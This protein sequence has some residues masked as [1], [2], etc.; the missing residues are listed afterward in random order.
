MCDLYASSMAEGNGDLLNLLH[1]PNQA[2]E[3]NWVR[4]QE[5]AD[6]RTAP[7]SLHCTGQQRR[8]P[9]RSF[10]L[11]SEASVENFTSGHEPSCSSVFVWSRHNSARLGKSARRCTSC[12]NAPGSVRKKRCGSCRAHFP[13][14]QLLETLPYAQ[15]PWS[16]TKR[17]DNDHLPGRC[18]KFTASR[19]PAEPVYGLTRCDGK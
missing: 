17:P 18:G 9:R 4:I 5:R 13:P 10:S 16:R 14:N 8:T 2:N 15:C 19:G 11:E 12:E 7:P 6:L 1:A 3:V